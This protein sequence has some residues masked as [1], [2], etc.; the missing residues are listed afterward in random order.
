MSENYPAECS[1]TKQLASILPS[2]TSTQIEELIQ[3]AYGLIHQEPE[4][5]QAPT[6]V[7]L[8]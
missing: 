3:V 8:E 6:A 1:E 2:L 5:V 7:D 4:R